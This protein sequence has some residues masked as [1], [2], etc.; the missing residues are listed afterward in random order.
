METSESQGKVLIVDDVHDTVEI[1]KKLL[2]YE[3]YQVLTAYTGEE[4]VRIALEEDPD[5]VVLDINLPGIDGNEA[6]RQIHNKNPDQSVIMLTAYANVDNT[7][8]ALKDGAVD[9]IRK[10]FE[11][12]HL[13]YVI[14]K[15][16]ENT[17]IIQEK[18]RLEEE[19]RRLSVTD[20]LTGL[21]NHRHFFNTLEA[22]LTRARR[23]KHRLAL[24][25]FDLD[26]FKEYNDIYGHLEG[27]KVLTR[28]GEIV[29]HC[30][31]N[32]VDTGY[33]YGGDEFAIILIGVDLNQALDIAER[34][35]AMIEKAELGTITVSIGLAEYAG[36]MDAETFVKAADDALYLAKSSGG[37]RVQT[38]TSRFQ[39]QDVPSNRS[40]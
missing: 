8:Q 27:D 19:I 39:T 5:V 37:N 24:L 22:E 12:D 15:C 4:G 18:R 32:N 16:V 3:G 23:Q 7:I 13:V 10:P 36:E 9:F 34:L 31:R 20:D 40:L 26:N 1:I 29:V 38:I 33:R 25:M 28:I 6:L 35:R 11:N 14:Q 30:I 17:R 21:Y 2:E